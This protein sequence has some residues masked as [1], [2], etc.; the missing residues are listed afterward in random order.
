MSN[1]TIAEVIEEILEIERKSIKRR[2]IKS[3]N[4]QWK[5]SKTDRSL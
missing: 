2:A 5:Q 4:L 1:I 3:T